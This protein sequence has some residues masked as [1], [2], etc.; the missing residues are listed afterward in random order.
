MKTMG[1][2][3]A[4]LAAWVGAGNVVAGE[5]KPVFGLDFSK[6][7]A[8][9]RI[10]SFKN[11]LSV[12]NGVFRGEGCLQVLP[13]LAKPSD[14]AWS[15]VSPR[16]AVRPGATFA[17]RT[18]ACG[19]T[20]MTESYGGT[21]IR[22]YGAD[23]K[24]LATVDAQGKTVEMRTGFGFRCSPDNW[25]ETVEYGTVPSEAAEAE[26]KLGGDNP[27]ISNSGSVML[28]FVRYYEADRRSALVF[29]GDFDGPEMVRF[30]P[31]RPCGNLSSAVSFLLRD[32]SGIDEGSLSVLIDGTNV[33]SSLVR[34]RK[35]PAWRYVPE[36][37]WAE[38]SLHTFSVS[39]ADTRG[40]RM[41]DERVFYF[42]RTPV[43]HAKFTVRDDGIVMRDGRAF[44]PMSIFAFGGN[45]YNGGVEK[46]VQELIENGHSVIS[47]YMRPTGWAAEKH[48][49]EMMEAAAKYGIPVCAQPTRD[50]AD[51][52]D[53][54]KTRKTVA[55]VCYAAKL[56]RTLPAMGIWE[57]GDDTA[58]NRKPSSVRR[59]DLAVKAIDGD[60]LTSQSDISKLKGR[61]RKYAPY[62]DVFRVEIYPMRAATPQPGEMAQVK[63]DMEVA[64]FDL[65][66]SGAKNRSIWAIPQAFE[67][68]KMWLRFPTYEEL[69]C[70]TL[71]SIACKARGVA[72][73][74]YLSG[75]WGARA[76][77]ETWADLCKVT[78]EVKALEPDLI[79]RDA[80]K[81]PVLAVVDGPKADPLGQFPVTALLKE[82]GRL[83]AASSAD[84][85]VT[86]RFTMPDGTSFKHRFERN[87]VLVR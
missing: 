62:T 15:V 69:R 68:W 77:P 60:V 48:F 80:A 31:D 13:A 76:K 34:S 1:F 38:D 57:I 8:G 81:Q 73:Y 28:A 7:A 78:R 65:E 85:P 18:R 10:D 53:P 52:L 12:T 64:Y 3:V 83:V 5:P 79:S 58:S 46:G 74:T 27:D 11:R 56:G 87:G 14:T 33:T 37:D 9:C 54:A 36:A 32:P 63:R 45:R 39:V 43:R 26:V 21:F 20:D 35:A 17:I 49:P 40:N 4:A 30:E 50:M 16:F 44:F 22:W 6:D 47:T 59:D 19:L 2:A 51:S 72:Y 84:D 82:T 86:V 24:P 42:T 75:E 70:E 55:E 67:G 61:Y 23:G 71:L 25:I 29:A 41:T 66:R